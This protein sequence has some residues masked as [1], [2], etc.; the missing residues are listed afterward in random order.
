[1]IFSTVR[2]SSHR[3]ATLCVL[4]YCNCSQLVGAAARQRER[5]TLNSSRCS[6]TVLIIAQLPK[7]RRASFGFR[8][9]SYLRQRSIPALVGQGLSRLTLSMRSGVSVNG[10]VNRTVLYRGA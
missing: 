9:F 7:S 5:Q 1:M 3:A 4:Q 6:L 8:E 2:Y 10:A